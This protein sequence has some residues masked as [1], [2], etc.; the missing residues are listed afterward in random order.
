MAALVGGQGQQLGDIESNVASSNAMN[1]N[2]ACSQAE[3]NGFSDLVPATGTEEEVR[4]ILQQTSLKLVDDHLVEFSEALRTVAKALR[5][6][7]E[8]KAIATA[9][10]AEWKRKYELERARN[11]QLK[12]LASIIWK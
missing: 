7:A 11:L 12:M 8:G 4:E 2:V 10:A 5:R 1:L 6:V 3:E 9:E